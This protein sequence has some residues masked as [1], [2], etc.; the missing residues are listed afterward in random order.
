MQPDKHNIFKLH[1]IR[2]IMQK[3]G[4]LLI[5]FLIL[6]AVPVYASCLGDFNN[7]GEVDNEDFGLFQSEYGKAVNE[8]NKAYDLDN[9]DDNGGF[10]YLTVPGNFEVKITAEGYAEKIF[11]K[12]DLNKNWDFGIVEYFPE[13]TLVI[14]GYV[15]DSLGKPIPDTNVYLTSGYAN[16]LIKTDGFGNYRI[17][18]RVSKPVFGYFEGG[19]E[20]KESKDYMGIKIKVY[21]TL[22]QVNSQT[23]QVERKAL[24]NQYTGFVDT[25]LINKF[26][27]LVIE[28][29]YIPDS[30]RS[31]L[32]IYRK[33]NP[34]TIVTNYGGRAVYV[35]LPL[36]GWYEN[37]VVTLISNGK[38][39]LWKNMVY[40]SSITLAKNDGGEFGNPDCRM[41]ILDSGEGTV[42]VHI[43]SFKQ[44]AQAQQ[45]VK[46]KMTSFNG[47]D[48][49]VDIGEWECRS[50]V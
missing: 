25:L 6:L 36:K 17:P 18:V 19:L 26:D 1:E 49:P 33:A 23:L 24:P 22:G 21:L 46:S 43:C 34:D 10:S 20:V 39:E 38:V 35:F 28:E 30:Y 4:F 5:I 40:Q 9:V 3:R 15:M 48:V 42:P 14:S 8:E 13:N 12:N 37:P 45:P 47:H 50:N 27:L 29:K 44:A 11:T 7:N 31:E 16:E 32:A 2:L 41:K